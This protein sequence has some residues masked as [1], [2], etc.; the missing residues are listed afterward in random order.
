M[1][2]HTALNMYLYTKIVRYRLPYFALARFS[3]DNEPFLHPFTEISS[4]FFFCSFIFT[5][6]S[7]A[8]RIAYDYDSVGDIFVCTLHEQTTASV[9]NNKFSFSSNDTQMRIF[10]IPTRTHTLTHMYIAYDDLSFFMKMSK[11]IS[12]KFMTCINMKTLKLRSEWK[13]DQER[14]RK[15]GEEKNN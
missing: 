6:N 5:N 3:L 14:E 12:E 1:K 7:N 4:A 10:N 11:F 8:I 13:G 15:E 2:P 9:Y